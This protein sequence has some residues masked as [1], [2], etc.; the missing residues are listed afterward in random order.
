MVEEE[1]EKQ[2]IEKY[3]IVPLNYLERFTNEE[4][5][6]DESENYAPILGT[7]LRVR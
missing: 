6:V 7:F 3:N 1:P 5:S 4:I 2:I